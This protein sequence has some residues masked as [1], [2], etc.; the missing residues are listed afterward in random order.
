[1]ASTIC[2]IFPI[3]LVENRNEKLTVNRQALQI[4]TS[5]S[6]PVLVVAIVGPCR[7]GKS[8]LMNRL[9]GKNRGFDLDPREGIWMWC[10]NHPRKDDHVLVLLDTEGIGDEEKDNSKNHSWIFALA[11]LLSSTLIYN[12]KD[13]INHQTLEQMHYITDLPK[14][15]KFKSSPNALGEED[16]AEFVGFFPDFVWTVR[17]FNQDGHPINPDEYLENALKLTKGQDPKFQ[18]ANLSRECIRKFF[19]EQK[20]F[21]FICPTNNMSSLV[22]LE[23]VQ[24]S[25]LEP[26]FKDQTKKF[27]FY[28]F[29]N[30]K[31]KILNGNIIV[32]GN[33]LGKLLES[34]VKAISSREIPCLENAMLTLAQIENKAAFQKAS[35]HYKEQMN[36]KVNFPTESLQDLLKLHTVCAKEAISI[37]MKL[38]FK[39]N[40][41]NFQKDLMHMLETKKNDFILRNKEESTKDCQTK[42]KKTSKTLKKAISKGKYS[43]PGGYKLYRK[44]REE[45]INKYHQESRKMVKADEVLQNFLQTLAQKENSILKR[46]QTLTD[47]EKALEVE[48]VKREAAEEK[49]KLLE[50]QQKEMQQMMEAQKRSYEEN[51]SQLKKDGGR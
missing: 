27:C 37:F 15:I 8:Y 17:D 10:I 11:I 45:M 49:N 33:W 39:Y 28:I 31:P 4:L 6:K 9:A 34:Y 12:S 20:C 47:Q 40:M 29:S 43:V 26:V 25:Q 1:M 24:E 18:M 23:D 7:T 44:E 51:I 21:T 32:N 30:V 46:D 22:H 16:S 13:I 19:P 38:S 3:C 42:L 2:M 36:R 48:R 35:N 14:L 5:I 50:Q 41:H